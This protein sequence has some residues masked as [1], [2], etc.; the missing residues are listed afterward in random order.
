[1]ASVKVYDTAM[2]YVLLAIF[3]LIAAQP[4]QASLC[5]MHDAQDVSHSQ[6]DGPM[7]DDHEQDMDCCDHDP[8]VP[9]DNC[10]TLS[11]CGASTAGVV[12]INTPAD[13]LF[14]VSG[15][16]HLPDSGEPLSRFNSP[17]F[18]PPIS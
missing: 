4:L 12:A 16:Q 8:S 9:S 13:M 6:H 10:G 1:M 2:K 5:D 18:R 11:H 7:H 17:P 3:V 14:D 15:R